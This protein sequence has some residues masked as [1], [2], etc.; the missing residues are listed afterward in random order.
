M[1]IRFIAPKSFNSIPNSIYEITGPEVLLSHTPI[2]LNQ[3]QVDWYQNGEYSSVY[4][5]T[6]FASN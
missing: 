4:H 3:G 6:K 1:S 2:T 5:H